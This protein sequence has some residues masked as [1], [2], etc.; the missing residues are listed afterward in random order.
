[1]WWI[2]G[3]VSAVKTAY[4]AYSNFKKGKAQQEKM[5]NLANITPEERDYVKRQRKIAD[6]GD[7]QIDSMYKAQKQRV[8]GGIRQIGAEARSQ[9]VG[10]AVSQGLEN[11][12]I[13]QELRRKADISTLKAVSDSSA[14][15]A[16]ANAQAQLNAKSQA[17]G[18]LDSFQLNRAN[19]LRNIAMQTPTDA[20]IGYGAMD[21]LVPGLIDAGM[22]GASGYFGKGGPG[23]KAPPKDFIKVGGNLYNPNN[24]QWI[25]PP[26]ST[27]GPPSVLTYQQ[28]IE[29]LQNN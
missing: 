5:R 9:A 10:Q 13:A 25:M 7:P 11:S 23:Y 29:M 12:I 28:F 16:Q 15:I 21:Q 2:P 14:Q 4:G 18:R 3:A 6:A 8:V 1:M 22:Q 20:E 19:Q 27:G 26:N 17:Q 24:N